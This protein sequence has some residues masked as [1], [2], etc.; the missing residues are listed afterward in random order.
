[1]LSQ[2]HGGAG[3]VISATGKAA[4]ITNQVC[5]RN[6][7]SFSGHTPARACT[8]L[9]RPDELTFSLTYREAAEEQAD[10]W[11]KRNAELSSLIQAYDQSTQNI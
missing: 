10:L 9:K 8:Q 4:K 1:M 2:C 6:S 7:P 5:E 3:I 11:A